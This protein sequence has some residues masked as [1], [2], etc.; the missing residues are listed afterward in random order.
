MSL[1]PYLPDSPV[2]DMTYTPLIV[3]MMFFIIATFYSIMDGADSSSPQPI[4]TKLTSDESGPQV[5]VNSSSI[6]YRASKKRS[7]VEYENPVDTE[8]LEVLSKANRPYNVK[9]V[10]FTLRR[11]KPTLQYAQMTKSDINSRLYTM[12]NQKKIKMDTS[13]PCPYWTV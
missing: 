7:R 3:L 2:P 6:I 13:T 12:L 1:V 5:Y 4:Y 11:E 9:D 8:I 10:L